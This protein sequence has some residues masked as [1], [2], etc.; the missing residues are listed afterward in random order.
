MRHSRQDKLIG[1]GASEGFPSHKL[2]IVG[3]GGVGSVLANLL[4]RGGFTNLVLVDNDLI[5]ET[6]L[7]RQNFSESDIGSLKSEILAITLKQ[8]DSNAKIKVITDILTS[9]NIAKI[10]SDC[11]LIVDCTDNFE[12]RRVINAY[13]ESEGKDWLYTG[14]VKYE[15]VC[16]LFKGVDLNFSKVFPKE[17]IDERCCDVGVLASTTFAGAS[18]A[19]NEIV[20]YFLGKSTG[21]LI[22]YDMFKHKVFE[23]K[24]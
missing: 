3:C 5:D 15:F 19:Y 10:S 4:V 24:V 14:A 9:D 23:V 22:K 2:L 6:N 21:K 17:V 20:K 13:C 7:Q 16:C 8:I 18:L 1:E 11:S 12:T